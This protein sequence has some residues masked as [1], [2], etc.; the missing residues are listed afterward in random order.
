[1]SGLYLP[2][3]EM[4]KIGES[5]TIYSDGRVVRYDTYS[6]GT[7]RG[8]AIHVPDHGRLIDADA[9]ISF[10]NCGH[11]RNPLALSWSDN[12]VVDMIENRQTIIPAESE[13]E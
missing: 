5:V 6:G 4:P 12:D 2:G 8:K 3:M 7:I 9:V 10:V 11:L 1:M 13:G